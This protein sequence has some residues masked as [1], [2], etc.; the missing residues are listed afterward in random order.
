MQPGEDPF[1][2][3]MKINRLAADLHRLCD[4]LVTK[5]RKC[6]T[7]VAR[8]STDYE[9]EVQMLENNPAGLDRAEIECVVGNQYNRLLRQQ[10]ARLKGFIGIG[11]H[12]HG[13]SRREEEETA[14]PIRGQLLQLRK[15]GSPRLGLLKRK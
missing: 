7:F 2:F 9:I 5:L 1:Q 11:K 8:L 4:R 15:E 6:V 13:R 12:H 14:Q 3:I 10:A